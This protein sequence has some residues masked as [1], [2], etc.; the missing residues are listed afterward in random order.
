MDV[1]IFLYKK[2]FSPQVRAGADISI[3]DENGATALHHATQSG[4]H[5][6]IAALVAAGAAATGKDGKGNHPLTAAAL[7]GKTE[8]VVELLRMDASAVNTPDG[9]D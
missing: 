4:A 1:C 9:Y 8:A 2:R 7:M 3:T 5:G 6:A